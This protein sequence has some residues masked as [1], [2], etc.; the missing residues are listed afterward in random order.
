MVKCPQTQNVYILFEKAN[1]VIRQNGNEIDVNLQSR[2]RRAISLLVF[3]PVGH[4][5]SPQGIASDLSTNSA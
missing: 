3:I 1:H 2:L 4:A 5:V